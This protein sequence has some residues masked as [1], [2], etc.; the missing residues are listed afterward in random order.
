M[1]RSYQQ[2]EA[3]FAIGSAI[4]TAFFDEHLRAPSR[5]EY[6]IMAKEQGGITIN[7]IEHRYGTWRQWLLAH[8]VE[9]LPN[10]GLRYSS[11]N[12]YWRRLDVMP[13]S[14]FQAMVREMFEEFAM[15]REYEDHQKP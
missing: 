6:R 9:P 12:E 3:A 14:E 8:N 13:E 4:V 10:I 5:R 1:G 15:A 11:G 7:A 2:I